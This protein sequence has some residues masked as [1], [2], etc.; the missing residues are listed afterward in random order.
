MQR[1]SLIEKIK[2]KKSCLCVGL[3]TDP[4]KIP[5]HLHQNS[6]EPLKAFNSAI[7]EATAPYAVAYKIN[8]AFYEAMGAKGWELLKAT[9]ELIPPEKM[10][11]ADA[12][13]GDIGNT[14]YQYAKAFFEELDVDA[15]TVAPY[16]GKD[17][18]TP[19][20]AFKNNSVFILALTSN[21]TADEF[22]YLSVK[23][24]PLYLQVMA[25]AE[26]WASPE[27]LMFVIGGTRPGEL[28]N[29]RAAYPH[30][31]FLVPGIGS[32]GGDLVT[33]LRYGLGPDKALL[34]NASRSIIY[35]DSGVNFA[36]AASN[37]AYEYQKTMQA[38]F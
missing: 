3:D 13:R 18:A 7:I 16:M 6:K 1:S 30:H 10:V 11:I 2:A 27:S 19:F 34:V 25:T 22:Q 35:S 14:A 9:C 36:E 32:Q 29:L 26:K 31:V 15:I 21:P 28:S 8:T 38:F 33:I 4:N 37:Q 17:S 20:L 5:E 24:Q 12:K 23:G